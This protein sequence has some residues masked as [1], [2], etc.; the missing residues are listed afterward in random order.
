MAFR[1]HS[2]VHAAVRWGQTRS[3]FQ[4]EAGTS[5]MLSGSKGFGYLNSQNGREI[6][7]G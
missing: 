4:V 2:N 3:A 7:L 6:L 1:G 5:T